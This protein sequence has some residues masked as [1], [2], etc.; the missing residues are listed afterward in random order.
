MTSGTKYVYT[1]AAGHGF[2]Y[3]EEDCAPLKACST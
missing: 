3:Q 2:C 1:Y